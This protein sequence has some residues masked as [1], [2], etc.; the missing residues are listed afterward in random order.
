MKGLLLVA[1]INDQTLFRHNLL[2]KIIMRVFYLSGREFIQCAHLTSCFADPALRTCPLNPLEDISIVV[3]SLPQRN[4]LPD[5]RRP[6]YDFQ[7]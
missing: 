2:Y 1:H 3:A 4:A 5:K 6:Q 7:A